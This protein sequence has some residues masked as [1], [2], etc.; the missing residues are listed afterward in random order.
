MTTHTP[1]KNHILAALPE[2]EYAFFFPYLEEVAMP[3][4]EVLYESGGE[5]Q[6]A[7]FPANC[8]VS[9]LHVMENGESSEIGVVGNEG[10]IGG[11]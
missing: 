6:Y 2:D 11:R 7:Y 8:I 10:I 4:G 5:L 1:K 9:L 3:L